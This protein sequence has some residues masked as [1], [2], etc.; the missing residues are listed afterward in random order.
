M[1]NGNPQKLLGI[2]WEL[3][4]DLGG[5][6][7]AA[8]VPGLSYCMGIEM[9]EDSQWKLCRGMQGTELCQELCLSL[10]SHLPEENFS[11]W[12]QPHLG[13]NPWV[14]QQGFPKWGPLPSRDFP[15]QVYPSGTMPL[16]PHLLASALSLSD[17]CF[18]C[19]YTRC[20]TCWGDSGSRIHRDLKNPLTLI[21]LIT[22]QNKAS[23][24]TYPTGSK[25]KIH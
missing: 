22:L 21:T 18:P 14:S 23:M 1:Q 24:K 16:I 4:A 17:Y 25:A 15:L 9:R 3:S 5:E 20:K 2:Q 19:V 12:M 7:T 13:T 8:T 11:W 6:E 10:Y